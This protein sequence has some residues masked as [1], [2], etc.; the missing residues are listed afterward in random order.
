MRGAYSPWSGAGCHNGIYAKSAVQQS[1]AV[2]KSKEELVTENLRLAPY[3]VRRFMSRYRVPAALGMETDDLISEAFLA[4]CRAA[5]LWDPSRGKFSTYAVAA[6]HN[7]LFN[8]CKLDRLDT[9][10]A[11]EEDSTGDG[12]V[13][14][15]DR[16]EPRRY[17][18]LVEMV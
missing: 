12:G 7:W 13:A 15:A 3:V 10:T 6:I 8:A 4:L 9:T 5:D 2:M 16:R 18:S 17:G 1:R 11:T 14:D